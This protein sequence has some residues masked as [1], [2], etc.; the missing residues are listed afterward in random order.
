[1]AA[2]A[3]SFKA[4]LPAAANKA[5]YELTVVTYN[6]LADKYAMGG[7]HAY[8]P[9]DHLQWSSR[10]P[11]LLDEITSYHAD[12]LCLQEVERPFMEDELG[13]KL[14]SM[15][16]EV[17]TGVEIIKNPCTKMPPVPRPS[18]LSFPK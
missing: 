1:M 10:L 4:V 15:N 5:V 6:I 9:I 3:R 18:A 11:R 13:P 12:I 17:R 16:Y 7:H 8:C 14:R 2:C